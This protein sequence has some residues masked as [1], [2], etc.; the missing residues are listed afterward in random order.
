MGEWSLLKHS[1]GVEKILQGVAKKFGVRVHRF[2]NVGNHIH[3]LVQVKRR[4]DFQNFLRVFA[5][6]VMFF[7]TKAKKGK[8]AGKFWSA[9]AFSRVVE[10][11]RDW[12]N[13]LQYVQKNLLE[14][15]GLPRNCVDWWF[16]FKSNVI[17]EAM[18]GSR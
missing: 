11:G 3:L 15:R 4:E 1:A 10:W 17:R 14:A 7:V 8:P 18:L 12:Q 2:A 6:K 16:G 9:L 5:Q 13:M